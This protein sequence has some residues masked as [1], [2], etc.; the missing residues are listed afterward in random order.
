MAGY[1]MH[2]AVGEEYRRNYP[3]QINNEDEFIKGILYPDLTHDHSKTHYGPKSSQVNLKSFFNN[4]DINSDFHKGYLI[5][6]VTDY[7]FYNKFL[8]KFSKKDIYTDYDITN[9]ELKNEFNVKIPEEV[10]DMIF[11][12]NGETKI[13][14]LEETKDFIRK[15]GKY[16]LEDI[17]EAVLNDDPF[18][19]TI[20]PLSEIKI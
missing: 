9:M 16:N 15:T 19:L 13:I 6:L 12:K 2:L 10:I 17:K 5:H 8:K 7:L 18:W 20:R 14:D 11:F 4:R 1:I 3:D